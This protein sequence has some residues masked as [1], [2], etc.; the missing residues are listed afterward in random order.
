MRSPFAP[1]ISFPSKILPSVAPLAQT[2]RQSGSNTKEAEEITFDFIPYSKQSAHRLE[3]VQQPQI[4]SMKNCEQSNQQDDQDIA[5]RRQYYDHYHNK[6]GEFLNR[7][8]AGDVAQEEVDQ[9]K[10]NRRNQKAAR[11]KAQYQQD[12]VQKIYRSVVQDLDWQTRPKKNG[13]SYSPTT[14]S[15]IAGWKDRDTRRWKQAHFK[16][17]EL[18]PENAYESACAK[19]EEMERSGIKLNFPIK[20]DTEWQSRPKKNGVYYV[21][22][23]G[24]WFASCWD[25]RSKRMITV[26]YRVGEFGGEG[27]F[28]RACAKQDEMHAAKGT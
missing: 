24:R 28:Q 15:Y 8:H 20:Q 9:G 10:L 5:P 12:A 21:S 16:V 2:P 11:K 19:R 17:S 1:S 27:A 7:F 14:G 18:G 13:V 26:S 6:K 23:N 3:V 25:S 22:D 4:S